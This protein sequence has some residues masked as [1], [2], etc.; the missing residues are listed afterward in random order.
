[1]AWLDVAWPCFCVCAVWCCVDLRCVALLAFELVLRCIALRSL[2][3]LLR[4]LGCVLRG[5]VLLLRCRRLAFVI[6]LRGFVWRG[7]VL[8]FPLLVVALLDVCVLLYVFVL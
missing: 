5:L 4:W 1:M 6:S 2:A 7:L 8:C 3:L